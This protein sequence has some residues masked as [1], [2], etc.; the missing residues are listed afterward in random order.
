[1]RLQDNIEVAAIDDNDGG[2]L[3]YCQFSIHHI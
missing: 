1:M 2:V 3:V